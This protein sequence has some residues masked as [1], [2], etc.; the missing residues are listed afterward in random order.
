MTD[1]QKQCLLTYLGYD[2]G[3]VDGIWG[4]K[5]RQAT[6]KFQ[7]DFGL[8]PDGVFGEGTLARIK[9]VIATGEQPASQPQTGGGEDW[10]QNIRYWTREEFKCR[11]GEYHAPYCS[12]YPVEPDRKLVELADEVRAHFGRPG[13]RSSGIRC[14]WHNRD[15]GGVSNSRHLLGKALDFRIQGKSSAEVLAYVQAL[16]GVRYAYAIDGDYIHMDVE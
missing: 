10:W 11:C 6:E 3:G 15:S 8:D 9:E 5:S 13:I 4:D 1:K 14:P 16:P 7:T 12:G 2:T